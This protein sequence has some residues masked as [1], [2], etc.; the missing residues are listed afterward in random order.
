MLPLGD[1]Y[2]CGKR[3]GDCRIAYNL[4]FLRLQIAGIFKSQLYST[5]LQSCTGVL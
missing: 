5:G 3:R 1:R 2:G 4:M